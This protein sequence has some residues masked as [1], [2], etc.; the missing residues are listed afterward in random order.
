[1]TDA[2]S[3]PNA[4]WARFDTDASAVYAQEGELYLEDRGE[5]TSVYTPLLGQPHRDVTIAVQMRYVEG[6]MNN[7]MGVICRLQDEENYYLLAISADGYYLIMRVQDGAATPLTGPLA[8]ETI[9]T[10]KAENTMEARCRGNTLSLR[11]NDVLLVTRS[12]N[13]LDSPGDVALFADAVDHGQ[14]TTVAFDDFV[15]SAP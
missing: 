15:L 5:G 2:F 11:V 4:A 1:M 8:G 6:T 9:H 7:W 14:T 3:P 10:G 12:D 13:A